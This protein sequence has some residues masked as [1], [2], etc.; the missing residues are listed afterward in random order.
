MPRPQ[1]NDSIAF[2]FDLDNQGRCIQLVH[3]HD[4]SLRSEAYNYI[5]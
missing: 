2:I 4:S 1:W 3:K 5:P